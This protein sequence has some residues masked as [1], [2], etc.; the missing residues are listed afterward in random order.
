MAVTEAGSSAGGLTVHLDPGEGRSTSTRTGV[1]SLTTVSPLREHVDPAAVS[2]LIRALAS[3]KGS[4]F[5]VPGTHFARLQVVDG[6]VARRRKV[7]R[8]A[9]LVLSA[10]LDGSEYDWVADVLR[11]G[12]ERL[13]LVVASC[14]GAPP[15]PGAER[16]VPEATAYLLGNAIPIGLQYVNTPHRTAAEIDGAVHRAR[17]LAGFVRGHQGDDAGE[18]RAAFLRTFRPDLPEDPSPPPVPAVGTPS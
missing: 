1:T 17:R 4:P 5:A 15:D 6:V 14:D 12:G 11:R 10:D 3:G 18:L 2:R 7:L 8:R 9:V 16:Y 13:G